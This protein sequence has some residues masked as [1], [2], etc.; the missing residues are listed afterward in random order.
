MP[1]PT[2]LTEEE[3]RQLKFELLFDIKEWQC[4]TTTEIAGCHADEPKLKPQQ[5]Q[6]YLNKFQLSFKHPYAF[7]TDLIAYEDWYS[8]SEAKGD[9]LGPQ[10]T[11]KAII[12]REAVTVKGNTDV[13]ES[14]NPPVLGKLYS[15]KAMIQAAK[16]NPDIKT[17]GDWE[18]I[19]KVS[20]G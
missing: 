20:F 12:E 8:E 15:F 16:T 19:A 11:L 2:R 13:I 7:N 18:R 17:M 6:Y 9:W 10:T 1:R 4:K 3:E 5:V 14:P